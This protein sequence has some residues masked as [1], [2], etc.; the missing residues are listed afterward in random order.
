MRVEEVGLGDL[1]VGDVVRVHWNDASEAT[2]RLSRD[3]VVYDTPIRSYG[4]F[5]G[6]KGFRTK[7]IVVAKEVIERERLFHYNC[8]PVGLIERIVLLSRRD[9]EAG[10][11]RHLRRKVMVTPLKR[12]VV[13]RKG[14]KICYG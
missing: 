14:G 2:R 3:E 13:G 5:I 1:R 11:L 12:F 4:V 10:L 7:H 8:I 9:L 6:V